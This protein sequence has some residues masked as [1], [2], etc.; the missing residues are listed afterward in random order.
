M[1]L[2]VRRL[3]WYFDQRLDRFA[4][5]TILVLAGV[6]VLIVEGVDFVT[7]YEVSLSLLYLGPIAIAAWYAGRWPGF[8]VAAL[9]CVGWFVADQAAGS[10]YSNAAIPVWNALVRLG[11]F[12][13]TAH[14][15]TALRDSLRGH[16]RL[17]RTD[18][19]T[20]LYRRRVFEE[21]FE[22][23]LALARRHETPLTLAY[24]DLDDF[25]AVNDTYGHAGGDRVLMDLGRIDIEVDY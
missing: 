20:G 5:P 7:G 11:F 13:I 24:L 16:Q 21:R 15:L 12:V 4:P 9:S 3:I 17:A 25:K 6:G 10:E 18:G 1:S 22:H 2:S 14:L 23:D 8:I 19:L